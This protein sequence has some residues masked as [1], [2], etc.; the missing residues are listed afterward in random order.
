VPTPRELARRPSFWLIV[1]LVIV[2]PTVA[3]FGT[4]WLVRVLSAPAH[5]R[6]PAA[7]LGDTGR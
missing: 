3:F 6:A 4:R 2:I 1:I 5:S 7:V